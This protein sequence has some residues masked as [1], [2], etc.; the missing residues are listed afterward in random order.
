M[1]SFKKFAFDKISEASGFVLL[2]LFI[3]L[4][5]AIIGIMVEFLGKEFNQQTRQD[6]ILVGYI[7]EAT[8]IIIISMIIK[9]LK[10]KKGGLK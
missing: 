4:A 1:K 2:M 5:P 8:I 6:W 9:V 7:I 3:F 10:M